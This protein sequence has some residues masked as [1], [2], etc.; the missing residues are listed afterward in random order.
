MSDTLPPSSPRFWRWFGRYARRYIARHF[1]ALR[2]MRDDPPPAPADK[3]MVIYS[4]HPSWWDPMCAIA[5]AQLRYARRAHYAAIDAA[6]LEKYGVF[7]KLGFFGVEQDSR[8]GAAMF[9]RTAQRI[10]ERRDSV[11]WVTAQGAFTDV[12]QRPIVLR[13]GVA[14]LARR[15][16]ALL[17]PVA[18]EYCFWNE[19]LPNILLRFGEPIDTAAHAGDDVAAWQRRL[20]AALTGAADRLA[21]AA[22]ARDPAAFDTLIVGR[23]GTSVIYDAWRRLRAAVRGERFSRRHVEPTDKESRTCSMR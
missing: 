11:L 10:A 22:I 12:R 14:H 19:R 21:G 13:P 23:A 18:V 20:T 2:V 7:K 6:M 4:N 8:R 1:D 3:A 17:V 16:D 15:V 5:L 9:L